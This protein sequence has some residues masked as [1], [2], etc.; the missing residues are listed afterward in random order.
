MRWTIR[1]VVIIALAGCG[2]TGQPLAT[3]HLFP[4]SPSGA[5]V[6]GSII[7]PVT[8]RIATVGQESCY[9]LVTQD[10]VDHGVVWPSGSLPAPSGVTVPGDSST[11]QPGQPV[12]IR[13]GFGDGSQAGSCSKEPAIF[14]G[15][16]SRT[17]PVPS[18]G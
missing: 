5:P 12:W 1:L 6:S 4:T 8:L 16:I 18:G 15:A 14:V 17:N 13:G 2:N 7:G 3:S 10:G 9:W 11:L